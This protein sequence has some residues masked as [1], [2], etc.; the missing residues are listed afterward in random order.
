M[1]YFNKTILSLLAICALSLGFTACDDDDEPAGVNTNVPDFVLN[2]D[3]MRVKI[4]ADNKQAIDILSG[5]GQYHAY[6]LDETVAQIVE[7]NG[8]V[9]VQGLR[10]GNTYVIVTDAANRYLRIPL[11]V[12]TTETMTL[13][14]TDIAFDAPLGFNGTATASVVLGNGE[15]TIESDT[16][17]VT[18]Q[19]D[20]ETGEITITGRGRLNPYT[21]V[22]TVSDMSGLTA[23]INV[24]VTG[25][26][27]PFTASDLEAIKAN[28]TPCFNFDGSDDDYMSSSWSTKYCGEVD[29]K[30]RIGWNYYNYY[31]GYVVFDGDFS[32]GVKTG[33]HCTHKLTWGGTPDDSDCDVEVIQ[34]N[35]SQVWVIYSWVDMEAEKLHSGY[36]IN[37]L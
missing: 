29:G 11:S 35:G 17:A 9:Y 32:V 34:N 18:A 2:A 1:K 12:Y 7:E 24:T 28:T 8:E 20:P 4:G 37:N 23:S 25:T 31:Y 6:V 16:E 26:T 14:D 15:Y 21:A 22:V 27:V 10:N 3:Q 30:M 36:A 5:A 13:S 33:G 19:V